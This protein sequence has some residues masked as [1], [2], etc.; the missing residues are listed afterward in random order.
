MA[1]PSMTLAG[2]EVGGLRQ[3][4]GEHRRVRRARARRWRKAVHATTM[5]AIYPSILVRLG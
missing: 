2:R 1:I 5:R 3:R 4:V